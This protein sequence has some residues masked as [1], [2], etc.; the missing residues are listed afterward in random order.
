M[1][2]LVLALENIIMSHHSMSIVGKCRGPFYY[3]LETS[4]NVRFA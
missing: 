3:L 1:G 2:L 4:Q